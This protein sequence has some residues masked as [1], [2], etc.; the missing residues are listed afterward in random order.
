MAE[1]NPQPL[2]PSG[3]D[4]VRV[5]LTRDVAFD[6]QKMQRVTAN[7]LHRIGCGGCHS[8]RL[9]EFVTIENFVVNPKTLDLQEIAGPHI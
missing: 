4:R 1:L 3:G 9:L 8:G 5:F 2:P 6:L 7:V